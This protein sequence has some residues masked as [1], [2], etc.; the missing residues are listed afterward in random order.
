M[1][2]SVCEIYDGCYDEERMSRYVIGYISFVV[3]RSFF[4]CIPCGKMDGHLKYRTG[5]FCTIDEDGDSTIK[6]GKINE[7]DSKVVICGN[8]IA[9][10]RMLVNTLCHE[11]VHAY[12]HC[13]TYF[14]ASDLELVACS[15]IRASA[16]SRECYIL[17]EMKRGNFTIRKQ[18]DK[19]VKRRAALSVSG[20]PFC[21]S[22][23]KAEEIVNSVFDI[24]IKDTA[25]F[26]RIP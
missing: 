21:E 15:E 24:C 11:L 5:G 3:D 8:H 19:C 13:T 2:R 9:G 18:F 17:E 14:D 20:N 7:H 12:D 25:P 16:L 22:K 4:S 6:R 10:D 1:K 23:E 26:E